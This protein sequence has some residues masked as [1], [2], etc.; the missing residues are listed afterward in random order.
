MSDA[1]RQ[2]LWIAAPRDR[3]FAQF[4]DPA[5]MV[6]WMGQAARL[7]PRP[8]GRFE[9]D[10]NGVL[11]RG[12]YLAVERPTLIEVA[13]GQAGNAAMPL[14][15]TRLRVEIAAAGAGSRLTLTHSGLVPDEAAKHAV[16]WPHFLERLRERASGRDPG[17]DPWAKAP[18]EHGG[19]T[20]A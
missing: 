14:G 15:A 7:E 13:W 19:E 10:I 2:S 20:S 17:P 12:H 5:R 16:G 3:V 9:V 18:P 1:F 11:I 8:G 6:R 4:T